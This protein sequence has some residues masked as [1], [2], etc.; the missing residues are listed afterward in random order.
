M[1]AG[2]IKRLALA[3]ALYRDP[4]LLIMDETT[5]SLDHENEDKILSNLN[6]LK[7]N[8]KVHLNL[9]IYYYHPYDDFL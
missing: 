2:Q 3:R 5:S 1:S 9:S 8:V 4:Q 7:K 6:N